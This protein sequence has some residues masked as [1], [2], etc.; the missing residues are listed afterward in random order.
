MASGRPPPDRDR[1]RHPGRRDRQ[2]HRSAPSRSRRPDADQP[3]FRRRPAAGRRAAR[4][5]VAGIIAAKAD[6][7]IGIAGVRPAPGCSACAHA[8]N[9]AA[10]GSDRVRHTELAKAIYFAVES[11]AGRHQSQPQRPR[12]PPASRA[13]QD[14]AW[15]RGTAVVTAFDQKLADGGFPASMPGVIAV[16]DTSL[17]AVA[18][19]RLHCARTGRAHD[20]A[21]RTMVSRQWQLFRRGACQRPARVDARAAALCAVSAGFA[22]AAAGARSMPAPHW[23][24]QRAPV[25]VHAVQRASRA[26]ADKPRHRTVRS[27][28]FAATFALASPATAQ[29]GAMR[30]D[31]H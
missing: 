12:G 4:H 11:R 8:G 14:R 31:L 2:R 28:L 23:R 19:R 29:A 25:T 18:R 5:G 16:S 20:S 9:S 15:K 7:G 22:S 13:A 6:N 27:I 26:G 1:P 21:G 24:R 17:A 10:V 30:F 3:Q